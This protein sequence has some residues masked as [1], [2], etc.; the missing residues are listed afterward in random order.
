MERAETAAARRR[1]SKKM[2]QVSARAVIEDNPVW[3]L[4]EP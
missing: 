1:V 4:T 3:G 2:K